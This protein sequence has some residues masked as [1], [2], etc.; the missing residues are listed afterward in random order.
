MTSVIT[1]ILRTL[2]QIETEYGH[3]PLV[4]VNAP[5]DLTILHREIKRLG[6]NPN[7]LNLHFPV[8]DTLTCDRK[9]DTYRRGRRTL[10]ATCA[11]YGIVIRGAHQADGDVIASLRLAR[12]MAKRYP[13]FAQVSLERL[14]EL[15]KMAASER[16]SQFEKYRRS[17]GL[18]PDF[19]VSREWP[20]I[21]EGD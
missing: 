5:F 8:I 16:A 3:I 1:D 20:F 21:R 6:I 7:G 11:A 12:A 13:K 2:D 10:T 19:Y 18:E 9:L 14:Q 17:D 4:M 15:Q